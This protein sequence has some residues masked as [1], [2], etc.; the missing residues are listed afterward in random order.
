MSHAI[1]VTAR[2]QKLRDEMY[3]FLQ[4]NYRP[5]FEVLAEDEDEDDFD[6]PFVDEDL[7]G[8]GSC[9]IGFEYEIGDLAEREYHFALMRW[10][11]KCVGKRRSKFR[12]DGQLPTP[13]PYLQF[14][15]ELQP[16]FY[17]EEW[18]DGFRSPGPLVDS[19]GMRVDETVARELAWLCIHPKTYQ[20]VS[21]THWL[22]PASEVTEALI[23]E[24]I[25]GAHE[26]LSV[27]R[28]QVARLD[29]MWSAQTASLQKR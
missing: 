10:V 24:G 28:G 12:S 14:G 21:T 29:Q 17:L 26:V 8:E 22:R 4:R 3:E 11:A 15:T 23:S 9:R 5:W 20:R 6:G 16:I 18:S 1:S 13:V 25:Q 27:I 19:M 7:E 2:T